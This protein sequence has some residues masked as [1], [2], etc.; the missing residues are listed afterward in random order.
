MLREMLYKEDTNVLSYYI[1]KCVLLNNYQGFLAWC[2]KHNDAI[3][4]FK[5]TPANQ[6]EFC[7]LV[8][9]N[10]K[11]STMLDGVYKA[12]KLFYDKN[13]KHKFILSNMRMTV[14]ELG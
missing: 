8:E 11:T 9:K 14:V 7:H 4:Q 1:I 10:Y 5:H 2:D 12:E 3:L 6:I 13:T